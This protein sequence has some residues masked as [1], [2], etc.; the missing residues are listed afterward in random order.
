L[1]DRDGNLVWY[2]I[3]VNKVE[4]NYFHKNKFYSAQEQFLAARAGRKIDLTMGALGGSEGAVELKL[5]WLAVGDPTDPKWR[6][7]KTANAVFCTGK[8]DSQDCTTGMVALV[9]FHILHKTTSQPSW[10]WA[11]FDHVDNSPDQADVNAGKVN[12]EYQF[13]RTEGCVEKTVHPSCQLARDGVTTTSCLPNISPA[14][15]LSDF[16][17][18]KIDPESKCQPYPIQV[19]RAFSLPKTH[20]N[21]IVQ[22]NAAAQEMIRAANPD[23][24][25]QH[26]QLVNVL[27]SD[28]PVNENAGKLTPLAPLSETAFRPALGAF[29]V[30]N[31]M[32]ETYAQDK[33][34]VECHSGATIASPTGAPQPFAS[35]YS[36]IF[37]MAD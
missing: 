36:F 23:S 8:G 19:T 28:S 18:G 26:Y 1:A 27:W 3:L 5:A 34:C 24:V 12:R 6:R 22:T 16:V 14:Y 25:F 9:G 21:P 11:T 17:G 37:G 32:L 2:E 30:S 29:K 31:P 35:D 33:S 7:Y 13:Y 10:T 15:A 4:Y 20:E